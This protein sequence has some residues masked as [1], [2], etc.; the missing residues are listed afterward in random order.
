MSLVLGLDTGGTFTDAALLDTTSGDVLATAKALTTRADLSVGVGGA[1]AACLDN[2]GGP[3][4]R[5]SRI[6]LSTTLATN[7]VVEGVGGRVG[8][9]L[10]GFDDKVM[11]RA[12]LGAAQGADPVLQIKGGHRADGRQQAHG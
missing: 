10:I 2:W 1:I 8:L 9:I 6:S 3:A 5:I 7:A 11:E 4:A 12:G